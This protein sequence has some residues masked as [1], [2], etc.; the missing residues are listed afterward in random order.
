MAPSKR[1]EGDVVVLLPFI[2]FPSDNTLLHPAY[3]TDT[4]NG[5]D[6]TSC[7][8]PHI[9]PTPTMT[10]EK[11]SDGT[12]VWSVGPRRW[13]DAGWLV[14]GVEIEWSGVEWSGACVVE[15]R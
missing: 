1:E 7:R 6:H 2:W 10:P 11:S 9:S 13:W 14:V 8:I 15:R 4:D 12:F 5:T 3:N